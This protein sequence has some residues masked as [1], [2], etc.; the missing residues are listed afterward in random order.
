MNPIQE[1]IKLKY[2][3]RQPAGK[4]CAIPA[5]R[6]YRDFYP[7]SIVMGERRQVALTNFI[8][9]PLGIMPVAGTIVKRPVISAY[10]LAQG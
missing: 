9:G 10:P 8:A 7:S 3:I 4:K 6:F 2:T 1:N 5:V